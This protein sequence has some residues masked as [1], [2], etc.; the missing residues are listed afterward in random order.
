MLCLPVHEVKIYI[1][2]VAYIFHGGHKTCTNGNSWSWAIHSNLYS[3]MMKYEKHQQ[4]LAIMYC[5]IIRRDCCQQQINDVK[6]LLS[7]SIITVAVNN[8]Q[9]KHSPPSICT[10]THMKRCRE[11]SDFPLVC[12]GVMCCGCFWV[13]RANSTQKE[14]SQSNNTNY[15]ITMPL[16]ANQPGFAVRIQ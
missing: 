3:V 11:S 14:P 4:K 10:W 1:S 5:Y 12:R 6:L 2:M 13:L 7:I 15:C 8:E 9:R 16:T